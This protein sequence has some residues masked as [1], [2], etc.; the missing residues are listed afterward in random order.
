MKK[1]KIK[2][3]LSSK[4]KSI[5]KDLRSLKGHIY[6]L[7]SFFKYKNERY[8]FCVQSSGKS[9]IE[10]MAKEGSYWEILWLKDRNIYLLK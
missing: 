2:L 8:I 3:S 7:P 6:R 9:Y 1:N 10:K 4:E 5:L